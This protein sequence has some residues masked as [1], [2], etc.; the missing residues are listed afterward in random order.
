MLLLVFRKVFGKMIKNIKKF[1]VR[2][3]VSCSQC[4][5]G[6]SKYADGGKKLNWRDDNSSQVDGEIVICFRQRTEV[7]ISSL[8]KTQKDLRSDNGFSLYIFHIPNQ[9]LCSTPQTVKVN[10][11]Y[12]RDNDEGTFFG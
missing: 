5:I 1:F 7:S 3:E 4:N 10:F 11:R 12:T 6:S 9:K 2:L 8:F